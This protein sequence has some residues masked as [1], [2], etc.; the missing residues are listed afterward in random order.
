MTLANPSAL[1]LLL[2]LIPLAVVKIVADQLAVQRLK[3]VAGPRL[4][5]QLR[6]RAW[7]GRDLLVFL[8][9]VVALTCMVFALARPQWGYV[10]REVQ[11]EGRSIMIAIDTSRSM[12]A[13][14]LSPSRL[15]RAK[16]AAQDLVA[17]LPGDK[18]G[19]IAF[20]GRAFLQAP[21]TTDHDAL[22]EALQ[23]FDTEI[24]PRGGSNLTEPIELA[25]AV[26]DKSGTA[27]HALIMFTDGDELEGSA[28][29]AARKAKERN[30]MVVTVGVGSAEGALL[31]DPDP[32]G[33][34]AFLKDDTGRPVRARLQDGVLKNIARETGGM[35]LN[36]STGSVLKERIE[37]ILNK[38]DRSK[39]SAQKERRQ[40]IDRY[41]WVLVPGLV[42]LLISFLLKIG[43]PMQA[44]RPGTAVAGAAAVFL[45]L[46][47]APAAQGQLLS[48]VDWLKPSGWDYYKAGS[49]E[50][51]LHRF[52]ESLAESKDRKRAADLE[53]GRGA[54]AFK[55]GE[56]SAAVDSFAQAMA[57]ESAEDRAQAAYNMG[58]A[59]A[60]QAKDMKPARQRP[61]IMA[62]LIADAIKQYEEA[63]RLKPD[64]ADAKANLE[65]LKNFAEELEKYRE[66]L[67]EKA[68]QQKKKG[69]DKQ[70]GE[71]QKGQEDKGDKGQQGQDGDDGQG[72][73]GQNG[74]PGGNGNEEEQD[75]EEVDDPAE[76]EGDQG[77]GPQQGQGQQPGDQGDEQGGK[78]PGQ[79][80][81]K[82]AA[83]EGDAE[84]RAG[85]QGGDGDIKAKENGG[86]KEGQDGQKGQGQK[87]GEEKNA[88]PGKDRRQ[89]REGFSASEA[90]ALLRMLSDEDYVRP[91]TDKSAA[92]GSYKDW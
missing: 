74:Q 35:Y 71:P 1:L 19:V 48:P 80:D 20:A 29:A 68:R 79:D 65:A 7:R 45:A 32:R 25:T 33:N 89:R 6:R 46:A 10:E 42:S 81:Q 51:A 75:A 88:G 5:P 40:G 49:Y 61:K 26:F 91:L 69:G 39:T 60:A 8:F 67:R 62:G 28:Q 43:R 24:I 37:T 41:E 21:L 3:R 63:L 18:I 57:A 13:D 16:L 9:E 34:G 44:W 73:Q 53:F 11:G 66:Q 72:Q 22:V 59:L 83:P 70:Q 47:G 4:L 87:P 58:N 55:A 17:A 52:G 14:D 84:K 15:T 50:Q 30:V 36:L 82:Q 56:Y 86:K 2:L 90:R 27:S 64:H 31:R 78:S 92:E 77:Q 23:Q 38:L 76:Q 85:E 12:L 54:A